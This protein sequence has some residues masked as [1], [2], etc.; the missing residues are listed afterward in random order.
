MKQ[1]HSASLGALSL[2]AALGTLYPPTVAA[3]TAEDS[4]H[5]HNLS[6]EAP[7]DPVLQDQYPQLAIVGNTVHLAWLA[8]SDDLQTQRLLYRRSIDGGLTFEAVRILLDGSGTDLNSG[9]SNHHSETGQT[10]AFL[11]AAGDGVHLVLLQ[12]GGGL[13]P[14]IVYLRSTD[15]GTTFQ[16]P[17]ILG[18][19]ETDPPDPGP[20]KGHPADLGPPLVAAGGD[21]VVI[22]FRYTQA[23]AILTEFFGWQY[24]YYPRLSI[25]HSSNG[26]A[27]FATA[28]VSGDPPTTAAAIPTQLTIQGDEVLFAARDTEAFGFGGLRS[29]VHAGISADGGANFTFM[30]LRDRLDTVFGDAV[31]MVKTGSTVLVF[32]SSEDTSTPALGTLFCSRSTDSGATFSPPVRLTDAPAQLSNTSSFAVAANGNEIFVGAV[33]VS[34]SMAGRMLVRRSTDAGATFSAWS[35]LADFAN[36][37]STLLTPVSWPRLAVAPGNPGASG[38]GLLWTGNFLARSTDSAANFVPPVLVRP[39]AEVVRSEPGIA[40]QWL[41]APDGTLHLATASRS[42]TNSDEYDIYYR[43]FGTAADPTV[44]GQSL[45]LD[46][47]APPPGD[48]LNPRHRDSLQI[49]AA[50]ALDLGTAFTIEFWARFH[51]D[52]ANRMPFASQTLGI[53]AGIGQTLSEENRFRFALTTNTGSFEVTGST[54]DP[55]PDTWYHFALRYDAAL[56]ANQL[57]LLINGQVEAQGDASGAW[58]RE[59]GPFCFGNFFGNPADDFSGDIDEIRFW[60]TALTDA[61]IRS[62]YRSPLVGTETG[63]SAWFPLDGHTRDATGT[64]PDGLLSCRESFVTG[65][66][67]LA[68]TPAPEGLVSWWR[69]EG[70]FLDHHGSN[71]AVGVGGAGFTT[72]MVN[73]AFDLNGSTSY[74]QAA[75]PAGLPLGS[76]PR[77]ILLWCKTPR[78]LETSTE[79]A[80]IQYGSDANGRMF[81]LITSGNAPGKLYFFGYNRDLASDTTLSPDTWHHVAV[82]YD[83]ITVRLFL[84]GQPDGSAVRSLDTALNAAGLTIGSRPDGSKWLGQLDEVMIFNRAL[85]PAEIAAI[86][87]AG[88]AGCVAG[89]TPFA[90]GLSV[91]RD[92]GDLRISWLSEIGLRYRVQSSTTLAADSWTDEGLHFGTGGPLSVALPIGPEPRKFIRLL[93]NE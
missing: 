90:P 18:T 52:L 87:A 63:L 32:F 76:S 26:G 82:T 8:A 74:A 36:P 1:I 60:N 58:V 85:D 57:A 14:R 91:L 12:S 64:V 67:L 16:T 77:T 30:R 29:A 89:V 20:G 5:F 40:P 34:D 59:Q 17:Q 9:L 35:V 93:V 2:I 43:R 6:S 53:H 55:Q 81:G 4:L 37:R 48:T 56:P 19:V 61:T 78:K 11:A 28:G 31:R 79:S 51:G 54:L 69:G 7:G 13:A 49:P 10:P 66:T 15:G 3:R 46:H 44:P 22:A 70:N 45:A 68:G 42:G 24:G 33:D 25:S 72:G 92:G 27:S 21:R 71:S 41:A 23:S 62:R 38:V 65:V 75:A 84:D 88:Q 80:L 83:G 39:P 73:Q 86:H 47:A 50:P